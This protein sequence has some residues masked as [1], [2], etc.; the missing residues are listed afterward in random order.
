MMVNGVID[1]ILAG[2]LISGLPGTLVWAFGF[3]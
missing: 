2:I 3:S 1:L